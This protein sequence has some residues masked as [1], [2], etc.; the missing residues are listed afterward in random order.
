MAALHERLAQIARL[1]PPGSAVLL[2]VEALQAEEEHE[3]GS[4]AR[5][6]DLTVNEVAK[7][8]GRSPSTV[9]GWCA[10]GQIKGVYRFRNRE[11]RVPL[12]GLKGLREQRTKGALHRAPAS[13]PRGDLRAWRKHFQ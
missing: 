8:L 1:L 11:W 13:K 6:S 5:V 12:S 4:E 7:E 9:R 10:A 2:P 3:I